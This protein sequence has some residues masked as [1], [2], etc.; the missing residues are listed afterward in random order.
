[1]KITKSQLKQLIKEEFDS[2]TTEYDLEEA[3]NRGRDN[4]LLY[5]ANQLEYYAKRLQQNARSGNKSQV[6]SAIY[7][8][9]QLLTQL[10]GM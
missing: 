10:E 8:I 4:P 7:S 9:K 3:E 1:M 6:R 2:L 5:K